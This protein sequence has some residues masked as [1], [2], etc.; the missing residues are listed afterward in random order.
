MK[1]QRRG[2]HHI[3][4]WLPRPAASAQFWMSLEALL[5]RFAGIGSYHRAG[6]DPPASIR[7]DRLYA[8]VTT[9]EE[10]KINRIRWCV[11]REMCFQPKPS[12]RGHAI[13]FLSAT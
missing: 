6:V 13:S 8:T 7:N 2:S 1:E 10:I 9:V 3:G 4:Y 12:A 11:F 5:K